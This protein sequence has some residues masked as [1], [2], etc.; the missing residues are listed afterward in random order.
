MTT[1]QPNTQDN[2]I[3]DP[4][5][6]PERDFGTMDSDLKKNAASPGKFNQEGREGSDIDVEKDGEY[7]ADADRAEDFNAQE[8]PS[9]QANRPEQGAQFNQAKKPDQS[10]TDMNR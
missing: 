6:S 3:K 9:K 7:S 10:R 2:K 8:M 1:Q 4:S 5:T